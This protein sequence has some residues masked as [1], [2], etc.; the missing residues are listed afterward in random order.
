MT[1]E[2]FAH[3]STATS[4]AEALIFKNAGT[5]R[6]EAAPFQ[7]AGLIPWAG[8]SAH[9]QMGCSRR[10]RVESGV[11]GRFLFLSHQASLPS[12]TWGILKQTLQPALLKTTSPTQYD[13]PSGAQ[14]LC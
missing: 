10:L 6:L 12:G 3:A 1:P 11:H 2:A 9:A 13:R 4:G 14:S 7:I 8:Q 5:A